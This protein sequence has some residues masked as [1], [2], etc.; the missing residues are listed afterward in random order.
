M[1]SLQP[2][3]GTH[4][5]LPEQNRLHD[6]IAETARAIGELYGYHRMTTP[7]FEFT[8]VFARTLGD[9]SDVVT[10]EMYS[11]ED[12]GGEHITLRPEGTAGIARA[13]ISNGMQQMS[14]VKVSYIG[15]MF[16]YERPQKGR[17]RQFH[18]IGAELLGVEQV[19]GDVEMIA[20]GAHILKQLGLW[21]DVTLEL[22]TLGDPESRAA[23][24]TVLVDYFK[25]H[26]DKLSE[27]SR[28]RLDKNPLRILDS[29]DEGDRELVANAPLFADY[30]NEN[31]QQFFKGLTEG[32]GDIGIAYQLN[33]RLVRGLDYYCH[34]CF[35]FTTNTLGAQGTVMAGGRYDGLISTMGGPQTAGV[36]WAA[37]VERLALMVGEAPPAARPVALIPMG[38][39]AERHCRKLAQDLRE[40]G[41]AVELGYAGN[42]K[43]RLKRA[44]KANARLAVILGD[45]ELAKGVAQLR[46]LDNSDQR[47]VAL[48][49]LIETVSKG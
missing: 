32:L 24:R 46:D 3:R 20:Y 25:G 6:H 34:T 11:F 4:D 41:I 49:V 38:D 37:G 31:S 26:F 35:E 1:A 14:P 17:Q 39:D 45:D 22:N 18:Q 10:K 21:D 33:P 43:K 9:T 13:Y 8:D 48:N 36:G 28:T 40:A 23:Y 29:K 19:A 16:R 47:E 42:M 2:V 15:P 30:L 12:R 27:D 5:L 7:I 44:D